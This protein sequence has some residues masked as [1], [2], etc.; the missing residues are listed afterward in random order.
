MIFEIRRAQNGYILRITN[1]EDDSGEDNEI[2]YQEKYD[3]EIEC[4]AEF[5]RYLNEQYGPSTSR[6]SARRI[7]ITVEPGDK[8]EE[9]ALK[10]RKRSPGRKGIKH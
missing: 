9:V 1:G 4:F 7:Y 3:D 2:V 8:F 10:G 5:L 6:Y